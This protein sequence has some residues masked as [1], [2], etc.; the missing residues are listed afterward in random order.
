MGQLIVGVSLILLAL[1]V[2]VGLWLEV[3]SGV[4]DPD[5][6]MDV[7]GD[8]SLPDDGQDGNVVVTLGKG[9]R[10][11]RVSRAPGDPQDWEV[12]GLLSPKEKQAVNDKSYLPHIVQ[13]G[14]TLSD[15]ARQY[16]GKAR[17]WKQILEHNRVQLMR[18]E[19]L[20]EGMSIRIPIW[21]KKGW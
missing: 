18:P 10:T 15:L 8:L 7:G 16:F 4:L 1:L 11:T 12:I 9:K 21:L 6:P 17:L 5:P 14:E 2:A 3:S 13:K 20:R 19:D